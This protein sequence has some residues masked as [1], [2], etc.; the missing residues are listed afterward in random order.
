V[1]S[2]LVT[3]A[4]TGIGRS[5]ALRLVGAGWHVFAG[6]RKE[7]DGL[8]LK[9]ADSTGRLEPVRLDVTDQVSIESAL[10]HVGERVADKGLDGL[11]NNAGIG[12]GGPLEHL[13]IDELRRQLEVNVVGQIAVTQAALPLI[14]SA[15][16]RIVFMGSIGGRMAFPFLAPYNASKAALAA[17]AAGLRQEL[18]PWGIHVTLLEPGSI[19]TPIW[20]KAAASAETQTATL[21]AEAEEQY[22]E[23]LQGLEKL[24][25]ET[26]ARGSAPDAVAKAVEEALTD[27]RP[28]LRKLIGTDAR[29]QAALNGVLSKRA[30]ESLIA[31]QMR[32]T[33]KS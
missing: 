13:E 7:E 12:I 15:R 33:A 19:A 23:T 6:V 28:P 29:V 18:A 1:S 17:L 26:A 10:A 16:G 11:V 4:S 20:D 32:R 25:A 27:S 24:I 3:G 21:S 5:T 30:F 9:G 22:G 31:R 2:A 14:R 8:S